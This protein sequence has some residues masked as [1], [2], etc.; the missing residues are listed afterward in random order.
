MNQSDLT[1]ARVR[2][3]LKMRTQTVARVER[4]AGL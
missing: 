4:I 3:P 2:H 1:V